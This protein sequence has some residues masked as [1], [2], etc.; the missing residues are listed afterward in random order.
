MIPRASFGFIVLVLVSI[1]NAA[2]GPVDS[3]SITHAEY[4][5]FRDFLT[6]QYGKHRLVL[7]ADRTV[8]VTDKFFATA[9]RCIRAKAGEEIDSCVASDLLSKTA[10]GVCNPDSLEFHTRH[11]IVSRSTMD[12]L[13]KKYKSE[14]WNE[15]L[16]GHPGAKAILLLSRVGFSK[17]GTQALF[18]CD[19]FKGLLS[20]KTY[21]YFVKKTDGVWRIVAT[22][23]YSVS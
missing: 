15:F 10:V 14:E 7:I 12:S 22:C 23:L 20:A 19:E 13:E 18:A 8:G 16:K 1:G 6:Q 17:D 11:E 3:A 21:I 5:V 4:T 9:W 2:A